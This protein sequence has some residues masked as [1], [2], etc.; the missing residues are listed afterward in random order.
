MISPCDSTSET[1]KTRAA[2]VNLEILSK[3]GSKGD[4]DWNWKTEPYL[5]EFRDILIQEDIDVA[6]IDNQELDDFDLNIK[7]FLLKF[8][9]V[10]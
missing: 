8:W 7:Q 9:I 10:R 5:A 4:L 2:M 6:R 3:Y 1:Q